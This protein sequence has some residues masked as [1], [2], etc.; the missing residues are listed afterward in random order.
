M[1]LARAELRDPRDQLRHIL[2]RELRRHGLLPS[3]EE[4]REQPGEEAHHDLQ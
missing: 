1:K 2:R 3:Y 4:H